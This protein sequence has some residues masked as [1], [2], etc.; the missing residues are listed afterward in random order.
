MTFAAFYLL[1]TPSITNTYHAIVKR[2]DTNITTMVNMITAHNRIGAVLHPHASQRVVADLIILVYTLHH[3]V[4]AKRMQISHITGHSYHSNNILIALNLMLK[5]H[6]CAYLSL[7]CNVETDVLA[8]A[9]ITVL[10]VRLSF[11]AR[12]THGST[13]YKDN[14]R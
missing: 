10:N 1:I 4:H 7:F 2:E 3:V 6:L 5:A 14:A 9:N 13:H 11:D 8:L 12:H